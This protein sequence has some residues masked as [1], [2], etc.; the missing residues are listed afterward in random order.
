MMP[1]DLM[2]RS[3]LAA[4]LLVPLTGGCTSSGASSDASTGPFEPAWI[5][6]DD[7]AF[8]G[9]QGDRGFA[10]MGT[11][12]GTANVRTLREQAEKD[13][14]NRLAMDLAPSVKLA[15]WRYV[16]SKAGKKEYGEAPDTG[17]IQSQ[18][19]GVVGHAA[20]AAQVMD[21]WITRD[22]K[23]CVLLALT[24]PEFHAAVKK[25]A[26]LS[27]ELRKELHDEAGKAFSKIKDDGLRAYLKDIETL[28]LKA[29]R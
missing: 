10:A 13:G 27:E 2:K 7:A 19:D 25:T 29:A 20:D 5:H 18:I 3:L 17:R 12:S 28:A 15:I 23:L 9:Q 11:A 21:Y 14:R 24:E 1:D 16:E 6:G 26:R 8:W 4:L 22:D